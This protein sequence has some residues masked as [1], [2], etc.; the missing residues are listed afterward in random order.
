M[1]AIRDIDSFLKELDSWHLLQVLRVILA[2]WGLVLAVTLVVIHWWYGFEILP[3]TVGVTLGSLALALAMGAWRR[4]LRVLE[5]D[6]KLELKDRLATWQLL[7]RRGAP[8]EGAMT[9]WFA[10]DLASRIEAIP[11]TRRKSAVALRVGWL[12]YL[13]PV[14]ILLFL[15]QLL[16]PFGGS[17]GGGGGGPGAAGSGPGD[18]GGGSGGS[19]GAGQGEQES[20]QQDQAPPNEGPPE[21]TPP[22]A[23]PLPTPPLEGPPP[24][25]E[26]ANPLSMDLEVRDEFA[27][28]HFVGEGETRKQLARQARVAEESPPPPASG[29]AGAQGPAPPVQEMDFEQAYE[30][31]IQSRHVPEEERAFLRRYFRILRGGSR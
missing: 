1:T 29:A 27:V 24:P 30:R 15:L 5:V 19:S 9:S 20:A 14:L 16:P 23:L 26:G 21:G 18:S 7:R 25:P 17:G 3:W 6:R 31:A 13:L 4:R 12:R 10:E 11:E 22:P 28:P 2:R 8:M